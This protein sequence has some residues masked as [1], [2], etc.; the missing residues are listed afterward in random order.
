MNVDEYRSLMNLPPRD[1]AKVAA[2][3]KA[4]K[5]QIRVPK[6]RKPNKTEAAWGERLRRGSN[7]DIV[8]VRF[9]AITLHLPSGTKYTPDW[10]LQCSTTGSVELWEV[11]GAFIHNERSIHAWKEARA[12]FPFW[13]FGFAQLK[14][15]EWH[16]TIE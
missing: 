14:G 9:E 16:T 15:T 4:G 5:P 11:K 6:K 2:N 7:P 13:R 12:A 3:L 8:T 10:M 1:G